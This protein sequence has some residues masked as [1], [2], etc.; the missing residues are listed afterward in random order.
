MAGYYDDDDWDELPDTAKKAAEVLGYT[1]EVWDT[2]DTVP[3]T[4]H[5]TCEKEWNELSLEEQ[6]A[7]TT[8][9]YNQ[10]IWD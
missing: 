4:W 1:K 10:Q 3:T 6:V 5:A 7:A 9:G 8:L 2:D